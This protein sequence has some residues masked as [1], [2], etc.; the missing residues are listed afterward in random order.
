MFGRILVFIAGL[1]VVALFSALLGP[2]FVDWTNFRQDF[3][4]QASFILGKKVVVHG[5]V[6]ARIIPFPS[7]TLSD[8]RIAQPG[9]TEPLV[10]VENFSMDMELAPFLS[11]EARIF[12]M[13]LDKPTVR[14]KLQEDGTL[15]WLRTGTPSIP[16]KLVVLEN[17]RINDGELIFEDGQTGRTRVASELNM[18]ASAKS[19]AGPWRF[20]GHGALDGVAGNFSVVTSAY[21]GNGLL[22]ASVHIEPDRQ[23]M[24]LDLDGALKMENQRLGYGGEFSAAYRG[25]GDEESQTPGPRASGKFE[26][27]NDA[28]RLPEY[29]LELGSRA[30]PYVVT[31]EATL[32]TGLNPQFLLLADGQQVDISRIGGVPASA[33][34]RA[35]PQT[36]MMRYQALMSVLRDIPVPP[37]PGRA[38][39]RLPSILA[40]DTT[41]RDI[42]ID[43]EPVADGW[44]VSRAA[45]QFP[46]RTVFEAS[47]DLA[48]KGETSFR[49]AMTIAS[50][51]P[52][53]LATWLSGQVDPSIRKLNAAGFSASVELTNR[54]QRFEALELAAGGD[55]LRGRAERLDN[56]DGSPTLSFELA[57]GELNIGA[58]QALASL[59]FGGDS[60]Q[61]LASHAIAGKLDIDALSA[62]GTVARGVSSAFSYDQGALNI[63]R[64]AIG[65][66]EGARVNASGTLGGTPSEPQIDL[67][68]KLEAAETGA[69]LTYIAGK[70]PKHPVMQMLER[71]A[72]YYGDAA[73]GFAL[74]AGEGADWPFEAN[75]EGEIGGTSLTAHLASEVL[76]ISSD[77]AFTLDI[78]ASNDNGT[79]LLGQS[80]FEPLPFVDGQGGVVGLQISQVAGGAAN[81]LVNYTGETTSL[82]IAGEGALTATG[83]F[84]GQYEVKLESDDL[85]PY[86]VMNGVAI[87]QLGAGFPFEATAKLDIASDRLTLDRIAGKVDL[88]E[89]NGKLT[90]TRGAQPRLEGGLSLSTVDAAWLAESVAGPV[91]DAGTG[92][93]SAAPIGEATLPPFVIDLEVK[94]DRF[95]AG[96]QYPVTGFAGQLHFD[97][98][99]VSVTDATGVFSG[100]PAKGSFSLSNADGQLFL[101]SQFSADG[102]DFAPLSW[103]TDGQPVL[104]GHADIGFLLEGTGRSMRVLSQQ[105]SGS[106]TLS[107][108][109]VEVNGLNTSILDEVLERADGVEDEFTAAVTLPLVKDV[110]GTGSTILK[111]VSLPFTV[112]GGAMRIGNVGAA[113]E[114]ARLSIEAVAD[115]NA[116]LLDANLRVAFLSGDEALA[117]AEP[118]VTVSFTGAME[119]PEV[120]IDA[121]EM[122]SFLSLR[123]FERER[124]NVELLQANILEKQRLRREAAYY[125]SREEA[126]EAARLLAEEEA[127][128]RALAE[129]RLIEAAKRAAEAARQEIQPQLN[130]D[131]NAVIRGGEL[132]P[133]AN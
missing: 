123:A 30:D 85:E 15:D 92:E 50:N 89:F 118:A 56:G 54:L 88:N 44:H 115:L 84:N 7:I 5:D 82:N 42:E 1:L 61:M 74:R 67:N 32:D 57:G 79:A 86:F 124:R 93:L 29:R 129:Q 133:P 47:G 37:V 64:L 51:Q 121:G 6:S 65:E 27:A 106:G 125:K 80:G 130:L 110:I 116:R 41:F 53:G 26:L 77:T 73:L 22:R 126:R 99:S 81:V 48:L 72:A 40:G 76:G 112:A 131:P 104:S 127:R 34:G 14:L 18:S 113:D 60:T 103:E 24:R 108:D 43:V 19:L 62:F 90:L 38:S 102:A 52:S 70:L 111:D 20:D 4:R 96:Y 3:E 105:I 95:W 128:R 2:Y 117:A 98:K 46:G 75:V 132:L 49:G 97:G 45:A 68:G 94:A 69:M 13:R 12:E 17:V 33:A 10:R 25:K 71:N 8:V 59:A 109:Q 36:A 11:G 83:L 35:A 39:I 119:A 114:N 107:F 16:A 21:E 100:A 66:I 120:S 28:I 55:I 58:L 122:A 23:P 101:R 31:G 63:Q 9:K 91:L 78:S 87:P